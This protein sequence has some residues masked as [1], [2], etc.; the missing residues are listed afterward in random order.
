MG[1]SYGNESEY[2]NDVRQELLEEANR[3]AS[4]WKKI[5]IISCL[6]ISLICGIMIIS[7][8]LH[9]ISVNNDIT[10]VGEQLAAAQT[11]LDEK[12][13]E[14]ENMPVKEKYVDP[15][16]NNASEI[17]ATVC[18]V[19]NKLS[20]I[21][22]KELAENLGI[23]NDHKALL[24][25]MQYLFYGQGEA[26]VTWCRYGTWYYDINYDY[27]G[28]VLEIVWLCYDEY[29]T[30]RSKLLS[31]ATS[32]YSASTNTLNDFNIHYTA[33]YDLKNMEETGELV[34]YPAPPDQD[35][36]MQELENKSNGTSES[37]SETSSD[38]TSGNSVSIEE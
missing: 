8:V 27:E 10:V 17:G 30:S 25:Q 29:D 16:V 14:Y 22:N 37:S 32:T 20:A 28:D 36:F 33:W 15:V 7:N 23:T 38:T 26:C 2:A 19:Q 6:V 1:R 34:D 5:R 9:M 24:Q 12:K 21:T 3:K 4:L 13:I 18:D 11:T 35:E 31:A